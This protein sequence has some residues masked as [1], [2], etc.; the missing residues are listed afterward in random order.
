M[1]QSSTTLRQLIEWDRELVLELSKT[2]ISI[3]D[4]MPGDSNKIGV[5]VLNPTM[6]ELYDAIETAMKDNYPAIYCHTPFT[7]NRGEK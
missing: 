7:F 5:H 4:A 1:K 6:F 3:I 2:G